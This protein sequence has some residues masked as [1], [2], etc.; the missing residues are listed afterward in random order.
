VSGEAAAPAAPSDREEAY[1]AWRRFLESAAA[2]HPLVLVFED[3]HWAD[4]ALIAFVDH[5]VDWSTGVPIT[6]ICTARPELYER[7]PGWGGGKRN[8]ATISLSPL[9]DEE[10]ARLLVALLEQAVLPAELQTT[11]LERAGGNPLYAEEFVRMLLDQG[12][13]EVRGR[14]LKLVQAPEDIQ[15]PDSIQALIS[16]RVDTLPAERKSLLQDAAV[17][18]KVFWSGAVASMSGREEREV[19][20]GLHE[21]ARKEL[22][23]P[24]RTTSVKDQAEYAFW[25]ALVRDV[26]Y[27]QIPRA[28]RA[29]RHGLAADWIE[30]M[31]GERVG[32][33]AEL[34]SHHYEKALQLS[35]AAGA[36]DEAEREALRRSLVRFLVLAG[37]K[38][39]QLDVGTAWNLYRRALDHIETEDPERPGIQL[40]AMDA[41][42]AAGALPADEIDAGYQEVIEAFRRAGDRVRAGGAMVRRAFGLRVRGRTRD[43]RALLDQVVEMLEQEPPSAELADAYSG[44]A[45]HEMLAGSEDPVLE[46]TDKSIALAERLDIPRVVVR[47]LQLR[48]IVRALRGD[49]GGMEDMAE[50]IRMGLEHGLGGETNSAYVNLADWT[51][52]YGEP[53]KGLSLYREGIAYSMSR[54]DVPSAAWAK[55]ETTWRLFEL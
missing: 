17:M 44:I 48:G 8:S 13:L 34:L 15:L 45:A 4:P 18:G 41:A 31:A 52:I 39:I 22:V 2:R 19:R 3:L 32:D 37:D 50:A 33:Q 23:R 9:T 27:A 26:A 49:I 40:K 42:Y 38:A 35:T 47:G 16:A 21:L 54:G 14:T 1:A 46:W 5:L 25:H 55:G 30:Q 51:S 28:D 29:R 24:M 20:G 43:S 36:I 53:A 6:V 10:T 12:A 7:H 11:L